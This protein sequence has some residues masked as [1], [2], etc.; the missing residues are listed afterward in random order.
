M[1]RRDDYFRRR[2]KTGYRFHRHGVLMIMITLN[3]Y[4]S[5]LSRCKDVQVDLRRTSARRGDYNSLPHAT[6]RPDWHLGDMSTRTPH[7][8][9]SSFSHTFADPYQAFPGLY[10]RA[11]LTRRPLHVSI[12][13]PAS[14]T[15]ILATSP[16]FAGISRLDGHTLCAARVHADMT[17]YLSPQV[18]LH[19]RARPAH[20]DLR[21]LLST[22]PL[23]GTHT[24]FRP[25]PP[26]PPPGVHVPV[27]S[28]L[29]VQQVRA[30]HVVDPPSCVSAN[31]ETSSFPRT[32]HTELSSSRP[33]PRRVHVRG[34]ST[35][36][37]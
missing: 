31:E 22:L 11:G 27:D 25:T 26:P 1:S 21:P 5:E 20:N 29:L 18:S 19:A 7:I 23:P 17:I 28:T 8:P 13:V 32:T 34:D 37:V 9:P 14:E 4:F 10:V 36:L 35:L 16:I 24:E 2:L 30:A 6:F 3:R 12:L 15:A 33:S